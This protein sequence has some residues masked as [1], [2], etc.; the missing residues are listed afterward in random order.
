[1]SVE[2]TVEFFKVA[3]PNPTAKDSAVQYGVFLEE[4]AEVLDATM[5]YSEAAYLKNLSEE[6]KNGFECNIEKL[7]S[8]THERKVE[9]LDGLCDTIVTAIGTARTLGMDIVGAFNEVAESNLSKF[10]HIGTGELSPQQLT[11][12]ANECNQIELQGR[13]S[14]VHWKR[15][16]EYVVFLDG[17]GKIV[18]PSTF[19]E[20]KLQQFIKGE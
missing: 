4:A 16:G 15:Q 5:D 3:K 8:L 9:L 18:K 6:Y 13:Y 14:G 19:K 1:M 11:D 17:N 12:F 2:K 7:H 10:I 20:P